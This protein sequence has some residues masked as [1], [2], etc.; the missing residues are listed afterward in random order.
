MENEPKS[1]P[2]NDSVTITV[3]KKVLVV[4]V[5]AAIVILAGIYWANRSHKKKEAQRNKQKPSN[6]E[7]PVL[8]L[9]KIAGMLPQTTHR[10]Q[11]LRPRQQILLGIPASEPKTALLRLR[12]RIQ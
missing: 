2:K 9:A 5:I 10:V 12:H 8:K 11:T 7:P 4:I 3:K 1:E 6:R